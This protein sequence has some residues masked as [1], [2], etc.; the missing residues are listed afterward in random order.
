MKKP[1]TDRVSDGVKNVVTRLIRNVSIIAIFLVL[2]IVM[3][4]SLG[5]EFSLEG[6]LTSG[7]GVSSVLLSVGSIMLYELWLKNG[8][9][10]GKEEQDYKDCIEEF[11][12]KSKNISPERMQQFIEAE[13]ERRYKV[14][15]K[16]ISKEIENIDRQLQKKTLSDLARKMLQKKKQRLED[17]V[18][19]ID[20]PYQIAEE[21]DSLRYAVKDEKKREYKPNATKRY[22]SF[23]RGKKYFMT[24]LF[25]MFSINLIVM[26]SINGNWMNCLLS[27]LF[28]VVCITIA[29]ISGF[30]IGYRSITVSNYGVYQTANDFIE[31]AINYCTTEGM[32]LYYV[33]AEEDLKYQKELALVPYLVDEPED[34]FRPSVTDVFGKPEVIV[35]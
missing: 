32:S 6:F 25:S 14:E 26:G 3:F 11:Q 31:K 29:V 10:N 17:H 34:Y 13:R 21:I 27:L 15:E 23:H 28:A 20:M 12:K 22:L 33:D 16:R 4:T 5:A 30:N 2:A 24:I 7:F 18:I 35:E 1:F 8:Q 19:E 9:A